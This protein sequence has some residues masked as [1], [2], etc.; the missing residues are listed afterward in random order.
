MPKKLCLI[1][2]WFEISDVRQWMLHDGIIKKQ[3]YTEHLWLDQDQD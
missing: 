3:P 2:T 1:L